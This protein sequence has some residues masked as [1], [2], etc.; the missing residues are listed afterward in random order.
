VKRS[1]KISTVEQLHEVLSEAPHVILTG[2]KGLSVN[3]ANEL[4][5]KVGGV[6]G[7]YRVIK[8]R[9]AK[10][11]AAGT[12]SEPLSAEFSGP[13]AI[14]TH[15]DDPIALAKAL[16]EFA[17][18]NPQIELR[19]AI[20]D[21]KELVGVEGVKSLARMP[22]LP[23]LRAQLLAMLQSPAV[24]LLRLLNTPATQLT[25]VLDARRR[26]LEAQGG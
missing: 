10:R 21:A 15:P 20:L 8:N 3:Q 9:L 2:F 16:A 7:G 13:C 24:T 4:R 26:Q 18:E 25:R 11:A 5:R 14:A 23:E 17:K 6:G 22:G 19:A 12:P 1:E